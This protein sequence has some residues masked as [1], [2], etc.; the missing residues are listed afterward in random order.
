MRRYRYGAGLAVMLAASAC[1]QGGTAGPSWAGSP[2]GAAAPA[3]ARPLGLV[4]SWQVR[5]AGESAGAVLRLDQDLTLRTHCGD[6][7]GAWRADTHGMFV[8]D[9]YAFSTRCYRRGNGPNPAWLADV[10]GF[11]REGTGW[12]LTGAGGRTVARLIPARRAGGSGRPVISS[13][14]RASLQPA[15]PLPEGLRPATGSHLH[16]RWV[17][18]AITRPPPMPA[19]PVGAHVRG[20]LPAARPAGPYLRLAADG[21]WRGFDGCNSETGRWTSGPSGR[22]LAVGGV[23]TLIGCAGA[24]VGFWLT[25]VATAGF[26]GANLVLLDRTG[27][28]AGRL[29]RG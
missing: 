24:P 28:V 22:L 27:H 1:G 16:G 5:T 17:P 19:G 8:A 23:S 25:S 9:T 14:L 21:S 2:Q 26:D 10:S 3:S 15:A 7:Q 29:R 12:R 11:R 4:G 6:R 18:T 20:P 13:V